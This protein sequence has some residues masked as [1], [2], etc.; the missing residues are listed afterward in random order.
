MKWLN[1]I[2]LALAIVGGLNWG[3]VALGGHR[4]DLVAN[5]LGGDMSAGARIIYGL[6]ALSALWQ[7]LP[8]TKTLSISEPDAEAAHGTARPTH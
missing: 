1:L 6:V 3:L 8:W 4:M 2:T 7:I 5:L